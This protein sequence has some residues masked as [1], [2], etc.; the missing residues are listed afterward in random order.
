MLCTVNL[1]KSTSIINK[2]VFLKIRGN[3]LIHTFLKYLQDGWRDN[4]RPIVVLIGANCVTLLKEN[5][6]S[7]NRFLIAL[8]LG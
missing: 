5:I 4:N 2:N 7:G 3:L 8:V 6:L 1:S